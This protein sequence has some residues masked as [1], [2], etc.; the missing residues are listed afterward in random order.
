MGKDKK[1]K[2]DGNRQWRSGNGNQSTRSVVKAYKTPTAGLEN[3]V[4]KMGTVQDMAVFEEHKK[5]LERYVAVNFKEGGLMPQQA[6]DAMVTP[7]F[8]APA[9]PIDP[10]NVKKWECKYDVFTKK[11]ATWDAVKSRGYQLIL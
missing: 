8:T 1:K 3:V 4:F 6:L 9:D 11:E 5:D 7:T 2:S 10:T